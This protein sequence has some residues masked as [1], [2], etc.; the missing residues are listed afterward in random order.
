VSYTVTVDETTNVV[1]VASPETDVVSVAAEGPQGARYVSPRGVTVESPSQT[2][3]VTML[4]LD[5][6]MTITAIRSLLSGSSTPSVTFSLRYAAN[7][8]ATG[9]E[10]VTGGITCTNTTTGLNTTS[11]NSASIPAGNWLWLTTT[12][13]SGT[14]DALHVSIFFS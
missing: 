9:T 10:V 8:G 14:V 1:T 4:Y 3:N 6:A 7:R 5:S 11:F 13:V 12:A 2:E